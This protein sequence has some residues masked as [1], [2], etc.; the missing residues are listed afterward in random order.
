MNK[1]RNVDSGRKSARPDH[2]LENNI[3]E[4]FRKMQR[5]GYK[6]RGD[7]N[8]CT[9]AWFCRKQIFPVCQ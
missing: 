3:T 9:A 6:D 1:K 2:I 5:E 8:S 7:Y 4:K